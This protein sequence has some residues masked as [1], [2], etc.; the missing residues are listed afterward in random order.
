MSPIPI[1]RKI[2]VISREVGRHNYSGVSASPRGSPHQWAKQLLVLNAVGH[3]SVRDQ[4]WS[5]RDNPCL[6][7][8]DQQHR[9]KQQHQPRHHQQELRWLVGS[10]RRQ[11]EASLQPVCISPTDPWLQPLAETAPTM[12][13]TLPSIPWT[14]SGIDSSFFARVPSTEYPGIRTL[15]F[16][17]VHQRSNSYQRFARAVERCGG[18]GFRSSKTIAASIAAATFIKTRMHM[19]R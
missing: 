10:T 12:C 6:A 1:A 15:F 17:S 11:F 13:L 8:Q 5:I 3:W 18:G 19:P 9:H 7:R 14:S 4:C 16:S 2:K